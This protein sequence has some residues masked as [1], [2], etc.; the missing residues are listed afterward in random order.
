MVH[1]IISDPFRYSI[2]MFKT[3]EYLRDSEDVNQA[4]ER[5][6]I[7]EFGESLEEGAVIIDVSI[8]IIW[9]YY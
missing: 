5:A 7:R 3:I 1:C 4:T 8:F 2:K 6:E 9:T